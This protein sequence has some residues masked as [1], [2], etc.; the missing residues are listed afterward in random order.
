M[1]HNIKVAK[2]RGYLRLIIAVFVNE[3]AYLIDNNTYKIFIYLVYIF[4][5]YFNI[6]F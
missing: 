3:N 6:Y 2:E 4:L 1:I 5:K